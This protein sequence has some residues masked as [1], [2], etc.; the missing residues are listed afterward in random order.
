MAED[1]GPTA[2]RTRSIF[3]KLKPNSIEIACF[4]GRFDNILQNSTKMER[5]RESPKLWRLLC[6]SYLER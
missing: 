5:Q 3:P 6:I 1:R 2:A 4:L